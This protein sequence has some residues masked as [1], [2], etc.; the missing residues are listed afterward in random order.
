[1]RPPKDGGIAFCLEIL[2][3]LAGLFGIGWIYSG[4]TSTGVILLAGGIF[5]FLIIV[6]AAFITASAACLCTVPL[7]LVGTAISSVMLN[8]YTKQHPELFGV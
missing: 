3:G 5:W 7:S 2:P 4:N 8:N 6:V 1:M